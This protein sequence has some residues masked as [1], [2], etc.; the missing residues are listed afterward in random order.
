MCC[1]PQAGSY[2]S[3]AALHALFFPT[4][5]LDLYVLLELMAGYCLLFVYLCL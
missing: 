3:L 5:S 4:T 2:Y 1:C